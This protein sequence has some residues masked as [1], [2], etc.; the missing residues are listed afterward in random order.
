MKLG[1][2]LAREGITRSDF[3]GRVGVSA[4]TITDL[5]KGNQWIG[6]KTAETI[7][8]ETGGEVTPNDFLVADGATRGARLGPDGGGPFPSDPPRAHRHFGGEAARTARDVMVHAGTARSEVGR[9]PMYGKGIPPLEAEDQGDDRAQQA[10]CEDIDAILARV[11]RGIAVEHA[12]LNA[13][14]DRLSNAA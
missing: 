2:W 13:L 4:A 9:G 10:M 14:L 12:A 11:E 1:D 7:Y 5:C 6:R 3:A 8:R